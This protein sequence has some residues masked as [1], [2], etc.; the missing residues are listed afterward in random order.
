MEQDKESRLKLNTVKLVNE[1]DEIRNLRDVA[2]YERKISKE[3]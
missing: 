1:N 2:V 3:E